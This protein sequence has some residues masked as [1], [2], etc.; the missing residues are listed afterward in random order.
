MAFRTPI[1][2]CEQNRE[3]LWTAIPAVNTLARADLTKFVN[4]SVS[5]NGCRINPTEPNHVILVSFFSE[6]HVLSDEIKICY[7][8]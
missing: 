5:R 4:D 3:N 6:D 1:D 2:P 8:F 7:I